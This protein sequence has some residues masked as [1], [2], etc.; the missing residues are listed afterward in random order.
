M[1]KMH[2]CFFEYIRHFG[3]AAKALLEL[4]IR[5]KPYIDVT[6]VDFYGTCEELYYSAQKAGV[7]IK[8]VMPMKSTRVINKGSNGFVRAVSMLGALPHLINLSVQAGKIIGK[9]QPN[10]ISSMHFKSAM[11]VSCSRSIKRIPKILYL[12]GWYTP[13]MMPIYGRWLCKRASCI[14]AISNATKM[15]L[16]CSGIDKK[17][18]H[19]I[20]NAL[21]IDDLRKQANRPLDKPLPQAER[22]VRILVPADLIRTKGQHTAIKAMRDLLDAGVDAV[23]WLAGEHA[24]KYGKNRDYPEKIKTMSRELGVQDRVEWLGRRNDIPQIMNVSSMIAL[25]SHSEGHPLSLLEA[26]ALRKPVIACPSGGII[27]LICNNLTGQLFDVDD[28]SALAECIIKYIHNPNWA[29]K[30]AQDA[31]NY[32]RSNYNPEKQTNC[33]LKILRAVANAS[34]KRSRKL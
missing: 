5:L 22:N 25:P 24:W 13:E 2:I 3:G 23:L 12:H 7:V 32:V 28:S 29:N 30:I 6:I 17:K 8:T 4:A 21:D 9:L 26:M 11:V 10:I 15:A 33:A 34:D 1:E 18:I 20:H 14:L 27:D 16:S 19:V 31:Q